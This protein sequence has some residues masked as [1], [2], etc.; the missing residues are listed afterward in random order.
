M[1]TVQG[2]R[3]TALESARFLFAEYASGS[4][5]YFLC[6]E[7]PGAAPID[8]TRETRRDASASGGRGCYSRIGFSSGSDDSGNVLLLLC[9][10]P[11]HDLSTIGN[12]ATGPVTIRTTT[13][14]SHWAAGTSGGAPATARTTVADF[15]RIITAFRLFCC[16][17]GSKYGGNY[18]GAVAMVVFATV[19]P[20]S[21]IVF[22][23]V[24]AA[25]VV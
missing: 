9:H 24:V 12:S 18:H 11:I 21:E 2:A 14:A 19:K 1:F 23:A 20:V 5:A 10:H 8:Q 17:C 16:N 13:S 7:P 25:A 3:F 22:T 15:G 6:I 4:F